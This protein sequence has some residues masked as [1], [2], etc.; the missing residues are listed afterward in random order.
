MKHTALN[1]TISRAI[2][3][4]WA[5]NTWAHFGYDIDATLKQRLLKQIEDNEAVIIG[6]VVKKVD[7]PPDHLEKLSMSFADDLPGSFP[8]SGFM[9]VADDSP[10]TIRGGW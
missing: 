1:I 9:T 10:G 4:V 7:I 3:P 8:P 2:P 6:A 5:R